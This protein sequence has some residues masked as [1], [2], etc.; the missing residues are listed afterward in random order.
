MCESV[1]RRKRCHDAARSEIEVTGG[2]SDDSLFC[3]FYSI[4]RI[5]HQ[6]VPEAGGLDPIFS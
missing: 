1:V 4:V 3:T 5:L 6:H 2:C